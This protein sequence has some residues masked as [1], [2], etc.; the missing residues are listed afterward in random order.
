LPSSW[1]ADRSA[2]KPNATVQRSQGPVV[3]RPALRPRGMACARQRSSPAARAFQ[4]RAPHAP[5]MPLSE[6]EPMVDSADPTG[7]A[8][9]LA[10]SAI[11][12]TAWRRT[13]LAAVA[14]PAA[15]VA[16]LLLVEVLGGPRGRAAALGLARSLAGW[17]AGRRLPASAGVEV[18]TR[19][20]TVV[21]D[22]D[23]S[24]LVHRVETALVVRTL[25]GPAP[26]P[27]MMTNPGQQGTTAVTSAQLDSPVLPTATR[28]RPPG[29]SPKATVRHGR[30]PRPF[31]TFHA[32]PRPLPAPPGAARAETWTA[33]SARV[34]GTFTWL[35]MHHR[36]GQG[37]RDPVDGLDPRHDQLT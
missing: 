15:E 5:T 33:W 24:A 37:T 22:A 8:L 13:A 21:Q 20:V 27:P 19:R 9:E 14:K 2:R 18:T 11:R 31:P 4:A 25:A 3:Q 29:S 10:R 35:Q 7:H 1:T 34:P 16:G 28:R 6:G 32:R 17:L 26:G 36:A 30:R 23:T 12:A